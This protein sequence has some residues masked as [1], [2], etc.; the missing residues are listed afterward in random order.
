MEVESSSE[1]KW[2]SDALSPALRQLQLNL[3]I[4][5]KSACPNPAASLYPLHG[6]PGSV[7]QFGVCGWLL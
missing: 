5:P 2:V 1:G 7:L 4:I 6:G 3:V